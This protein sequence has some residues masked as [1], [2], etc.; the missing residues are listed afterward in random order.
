MIHAI[1]KDI[2][3]YQRT[4]DQIPAYTPVENSWLHKGN[5]FLGQ[6][7]HIEKS[8]PPLPLYTGPAFCKRIL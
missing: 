4:A 6:K 1:L 5:N 3:S 2:C 8:P 7:Q